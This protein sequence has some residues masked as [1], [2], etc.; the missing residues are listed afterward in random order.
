MSAQF[1]HSRRPVD[2]PGRLPDRAGNCDAARPV[3]CL[4]IEG[5]EPGRFQ[6][7]GDFATQ[8]W[9]TATVAANRRTDAICS[10]IGYV[11]AGLAFAWGVLPPLLMWIAGGTPA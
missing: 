5:A 6:S 2:N 3:L 4:A 9:L 10:V 8:T 11:I 1:P 7:D